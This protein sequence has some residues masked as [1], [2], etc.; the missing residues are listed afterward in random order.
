MVDSVTVPHS[1]TVHAF[2]SSDIPVVLNSLFSVYQ[3]A[4][5]TC[6]VKSRGVGN[7]EIQGSLL[8]FDLHA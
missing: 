6:T 1:N 7:N 2:S 5:V 8:T 4:Q 3:P